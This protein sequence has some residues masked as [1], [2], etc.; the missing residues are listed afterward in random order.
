M[1]RFANFVGQSFKIL[2]NFTRKQKNYVANGPTLPPPL[3][4]QMFSA[5]QI[6]MLLNLKLLITMQIQTISQSLV[7]KWNR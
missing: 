5:N 3:T 4:V 2:T 6:L 1:L 7:L